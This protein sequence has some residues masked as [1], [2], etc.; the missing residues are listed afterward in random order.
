MPNLE[1][2]IQSET[3][4]D[5][6]YCRHSKYKMGKPFCGRKKVKFCKVN[7]GKKCETI[8]PIENFQN[9]KSE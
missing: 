4:K 7:I 8:G 2:N 9:T 6:K 1:N 5:K 3:M